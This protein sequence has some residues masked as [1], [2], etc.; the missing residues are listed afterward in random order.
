[1]K[2]SVNFLLSFF[3]LLQFAGAQTHPKNVI[4]MIGDGMGLG[5]IYA[6]HVPVNVSLTPPIKL[7]LRAGDKLVVIADIADACDVTVSFLELDA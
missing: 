1:M 4:I 7:N 5:Q 3:F 2:K 6:I